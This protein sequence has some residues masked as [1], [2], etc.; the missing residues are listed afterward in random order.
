MIGD[1]M[2]KM[3]DEG[4]ASIDQWGYMNQDN[5]LEK[6]SA[7]G[8]VIMIDDSNGDQV[9]IYLEDIPMLIKALQEAYEYLGSPT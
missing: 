4:P 3:V 9:N 2:I 5:E 6:V 8:N 1:I 7:E